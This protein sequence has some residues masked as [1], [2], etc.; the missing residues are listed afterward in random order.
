MWKPIVFQKEDKPKLLP[1]QITSRISAFQLLKTPE[2][3]TEGPAPPAPQ[4][5]AP[6]LHKSQKRRFKFVSGSK[7]KDPSPILSTKT[8]PGTT[9]SSIIGEA[10]S[11]PAA[12]DTFLSTQPA[13]KNSHLIVFQKQDKSKSP[14]VKVKYISLTHQFSNPVLESPPTAPL[15]A[16][17]EAPIT[18]QSKPR[19]CILKLSS[20]S[21]RK[22]SAPILASHAISISTISSTT[23]EIK[24]SSINA[25]I[26]PPS[27]EVIPLKPAAGQT[28]LAVLTQHSALLSATS[29]RSVTPT[30]GITNSGNPSGTASKDSGETTSNSKSTSTVIQQ[31]SP[32]KAVTQAAP[33]VR[34]FLL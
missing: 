20:L 9:I 2:S 29:I 17:A 22:M 25:S 24:S 32:Q 19:K 33:L 26:S 18:A 31:A 15:T 4:G 13:A 8:A 28:N 21:Q 34:V 23:N 1:I 14:H 7:K 3:S 16:L 30:H 6:T 11:P 12:A 27:P 5:P 10:V